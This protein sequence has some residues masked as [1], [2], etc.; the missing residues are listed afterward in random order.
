LPGGTASDGLG[1]TDALIQIEQVKGSPYAD[2]IFGDPLANRLDGGD[3]NDTMIGGPGGPDALFG[4]G[5]NDSLIGTNANDFLDGGD[6]DDSL[7]TGFGN[8][9]LVGGA[10]DDTLVGGAG[11]DLL[12]GGDGN[13]IFKW[14][15][16]DHGTIAVPDIDTIAL[17]QGPAPNDKID[18]R[19][20]LVGET[21]SGVDPGNLANYL[22][23]DVSGGNTT[24]QVQ[25]QG[26]GGVD[27]QIVIVGFD[28]T[29]G[30][31]LV[32]DNAIIGSLFAGS[33]LITD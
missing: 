6:G 12:D 2:T 3:G 20:V 19:D 1:G 21:H 27:L 26:T 10:G 9:T 15:V 5:G 13:D 18:L 24:V 17:L 25:T 29:Q 16:D 33:R 23:F 4:D 31:T 30:G 8:N 32:G 7:K 11:N 22:H 14:G 28:A